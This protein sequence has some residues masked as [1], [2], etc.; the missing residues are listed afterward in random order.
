MME[1][2]T[3]PGA[4]LPGWTSLAQGQQRGASISRGPAGHIHLDYGNITV[5]LETD[6][7]LA[8]ARMVAEAAGHLGDTTPLLPPPLAHGM[9]SSFSLN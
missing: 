7:F 4:P 5:R 3:Q 1:Q 9:G 6:E 2:A 8:F